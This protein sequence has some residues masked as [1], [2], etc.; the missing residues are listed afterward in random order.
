MKLSPYLSFPL[1]CLSGDSGGPY[2]AGG[3]AYGTH[4][5]SNPLQGNFCIYMAI[6]Y[7][8]DLGVYL[9]IP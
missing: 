6:D 3:L 4:K 8:Y 7:F 5:G 9:W 2:H 1:Y